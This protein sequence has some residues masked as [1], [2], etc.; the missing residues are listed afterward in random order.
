MMKLRHFRK[1]GS[2]EQLFPVFNDLKING[3]GPVAGAYKIPGLSQIPLTTIQNIWN[4]IHSKY[5]S[6]QTQILTIDNIYEYDD[7]YI[8]CLPFQIIKC[9]SPKHNVHQIIKREA[10]SRYLLL[11]DYNLTAKD[12]KKG[13]YNIKNI[14][15]LYRIFICD[16]YFVLNYCHSIGDGLSVLL[17]INNFLEILNNDKSFNDK[18]VSFNTIEQCIKPQ[19]SSSTIFRKI[20]DFIPMSVA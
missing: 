4:K 9:D 12:I 10:N 3:W 20:T 2:M 14:N 15:P 18:I 16:D 1:L 19:Y 17:W 5:E 7:F 13:N 6:L 11:N 8:G